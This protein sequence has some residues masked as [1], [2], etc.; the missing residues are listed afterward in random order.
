MEPVDNI[1]TTQSASPFIIREGVY[2]WNIDAI[3]Q[4]IP[5]GTTYKRTDKYVSILE[6]HIDYDPMT[7]MI[8]ASILTTNPIIA[9]DVNQTDFRLCSCC[10]IGRARS[11]T[12]ILTTHNTTFYIC[13]LHAGEAIR[14]REQWTN[15][16][17]VFEYI[18]SIRISDNPIYVALYLHAD[19]LRKFHVSV[20]DA[21][22]YNYPLMRK[23]LDT[24]RYGCILCNAPTIC[25][26]LA[27]C[28]KCLNYARSIFIDNHWTL[29]ALAAELCD[30]FLIGDITPLVQLSLTAALID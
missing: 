10:G 22:L 9:R 5:I 26:D 12:H 28:S 1:N 30:Q 25:Q 17:P 29:Y 20:V 23:E 6:C 4:N 14:Q 19:V 15:R 24:R 2:T 27:E 7:N 3:N 13:E 11:A 18:G 8:W 16:G 21:K